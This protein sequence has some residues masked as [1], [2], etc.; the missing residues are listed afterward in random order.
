MRKNGVSIITVNFGSSSKLG[1]LK[2]S[3]LKYAPKI[4]WE[5][6][7]VDNFKNEAETQAVK[8]LANTHPNIHAITLSQN[9]GYGEG[10]FEGVRF[11][12]YQTLAI[13]N[14]DIEL[15]QHT[16]DE[17]INTLQTQT[18]P[19]ICVPVLQTKDGQILENMR[20]F[21]RVLPLLKRRLFGDQIVRQHPQKNQVSDW[22]QG[23]FWVLKKEVFNQLNGFDNRFFLFF[24]DT[25]FCRRLKQTHG[26]T[27]QVVTATAYHDP[28]RLSGGNIF[29]ALFRKTF[30]IHIHS[31]FKYFA[32]WGLK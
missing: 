10:N 26:Q 27:L 3:L 32:K 12:R 6:I 9:L 31:M 22:A 18:K 8:T 29:K 4:D 25:D 5:W 2:A 23:S 11:A 17:L 21:P 24:E 16:L 28:N 15:H 13:V 1:R 14:P 7:I 20:P 30:W 19:T